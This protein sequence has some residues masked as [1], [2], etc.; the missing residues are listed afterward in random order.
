MLQHHSK[1]LYVYIKQGKL[2]L[3]RLNLCL[4]EITYFLIL[5]LWCLVICLGWDVLGQGQ[6][7]FLP[8]C[9]IEGCQGMRSPLAIWKAVVNAH[10]DMKYQKTARCS[11]ILTSQDSWESTFFTLVL[12]SQKVFASVAAQYRK[13][14]LLIQASSLKRG[15]L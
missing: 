15:R 1:C 9:Q 10:A 6:E 14:T 12:L 5:L 13:R 7:L 8:P 3:A 2:A 11:L 4:T